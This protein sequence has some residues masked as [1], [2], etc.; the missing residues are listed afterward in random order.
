M[1]V[2][3]FSGG[4][5]SLACLYLLRY[6]W[7]RLTVLWVNT[8]AAY[9]ETIEQMRKVREMV[10]HFLEVKS[11]QPSQIEANG[12]PADVVPIRST[13]LGQRIHGPS[14]LMQS[15]LG[16]C[17]DNLWKPAQDAIKALGATVVIRGQRNT[18]SRKS[19]I[20]SGHIEDG[21]KYLFPIQDW[22]EKQ[23]RDYLTSQGVELPPHYAY[24]NSSLDCWNCTAYMDHNVGRAKHMREKHP[25]LWWQYK[26]MLSSVVNAVRDELR[27]AELALG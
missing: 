3:E 27:H 1:M 19:P 21:V 11:D 20:R 12:L 7:P 14:T 5:D 24:F 2:L 18:D 16:C 10:P 26:P 6:E 15:F 25:D 17:H 4:K 13:V 23:V 22:T 8:G 9:P